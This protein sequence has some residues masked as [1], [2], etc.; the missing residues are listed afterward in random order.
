MADMLGLIVD[1]SPDAVVLLDAAGNVMN[2]GAAAERILGWKAAECIGKPIEELLATDGVEGSLRILWERV[3][4]DGQARGVISHRHKDGSLLCIEVSWRAVRETTGEMKCVVASK[5]DVTREVVDRDALAVADAYGSLLESLP[6]AAI[7]ANDVGLII[8]SN[9][10]AAKMFGWPR[11]ELLGKSI[12]LLMPG[13]FRTGHVAHRIGFQRA[14]QRRMMGTGQELIGK[15]KDATEFPL[16]IGLSELSASGRSFVMC[17]IRDLTERRQ[18]EQAWQEAE[19]ARK[20]NTAKTQFLS[21]MSHEL[22]TPLNAVLGF[23][24]LLEMD[25]EKRLNFAQRRF[26]RHIN[27]AGQHLLDM[28]SDLM[29]ISRIEADTMSVVLSDVDVMSVIAESVAMTEP[30]AAEAGVT[31]RLEE[32]LGK[33]KGM[34]DRMRLRQVLTN[35]ITNAIKYNKP[36]GEVQISAWEEKGLVVIHVSDTG[37]GMSEDQIGRLYEPF[38]RLGAERWGI[39]GSG[40]GLVIARGLTEKMGGSLGVVSKEGVGSTFTVALQSAEG[41]LA[42]EMEDRRKAWSGSMQQAGAGEGRMRVVYVEDDE[43]NIELLRSVLGMRKEWSMTAVRSA[44][45]AIAEIKMDR[46]D[47]LIVDMHLPDM[48]GV[49]MVQALERDPICASV[50]RI[51]LSADALEGS[52]RR[53]LDAGFS[54]YFTKPLEIMKFIEFMDEIANGS[55]GWERAH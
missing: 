49:E 40:I 23:S 42:E 9:S 29:D 32:K 21:R 20:A 19:A 37:I 2:W 43:A 47:L 27:K 10:E 34:A 50:P 33:V 6:D 25:T 31:I 11:E 54:R 8:L 30:A 53:A 46:P 48:N 41:E 26:V 17:S 12:E 44:Q 13:K 1:N 3:R 5:R 7:V 38:N 52:V 22:R 16:E 35:L 39:E 14:P 18:A 4:E 45:E 15:R 55:S 51:A 36:K 28:I 24:Q